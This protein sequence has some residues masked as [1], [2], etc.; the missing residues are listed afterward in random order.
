LSVG[1]ANINDKTAFQGFLDNFTT[2]FPSIKKIWAD[3]DYQSQALQF[4][5]LNDYQID[6]ENV[7]ELDIG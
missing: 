6:F 1:A 7:Q 2:C 5:C 3:M 4:K